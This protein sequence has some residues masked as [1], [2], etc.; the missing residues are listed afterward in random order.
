MSKV[1]FKVRITVEL[2]DGVVQ[3]KLALQE[4]TGD[5]LKEELV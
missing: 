1:Q 3:E 2:D 5:L 4:I